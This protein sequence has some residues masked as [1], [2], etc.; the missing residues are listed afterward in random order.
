MFSDL[1]DDQGP[2]EKDRKII[3]LIMQQGKSI[4][5]FEITNENEKPV[6]VGVNFL[7]CCD[8]QIEKEISQ[9]EVSR[10]R[11]ISDVFVQT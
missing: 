5:T 2:I 10:M 11:M 7:Y 4:A 8:A 3:E 6:F 9:I 1:T